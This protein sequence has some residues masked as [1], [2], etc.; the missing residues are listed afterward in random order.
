MNKISYYEEIWKK[1]HKN[2]SKMESTWDA[3]AESFSSAQ[4]RSLEATPE[5][6]VEH[7]LNN[8]LIDE[9]SRVLDIGGGSGRYAIPIS[10]KVKQVVLTDISSKMLKYAAE[11]AEQAGVSNIEYLKF[12]LE[13]A[14]IKEVGWDKKFDLVFATMCPAIRDETALDKMILASKKSCFIGQY[15]QTTNNISQAI[16]KA[17]N[18]SNKKDPHN[19]KD[20]VYAIFNILWL[21][22]HEP[23]ISYVKEERVEEFT[24]DAAFKKYASPYA[25]EAEERNI[26][27]KKL[28]I[29]LS[30]DNKVTVTTKKNLALIHWDVV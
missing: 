8:K 9:N 3:R 13:E 10:E 16:M 27:L 2:G 26:D 14:N 28:M 7:L 25:Q 1:D 23:S 21:K 19:D 20:A 15:I 29:D 17:L 24:V 22:G 18:I 6:V 30:N 5:K 12:D 4:N 11:N